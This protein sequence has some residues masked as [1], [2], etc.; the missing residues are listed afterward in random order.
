MIKFKITF[1]T[2]SNPADKQL[3]AWLTESINHNISIISMKYQQAR[4]G[5]HSICIMYEEKNQ[6]RKES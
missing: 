5:D 2:V 3:N 6:R 1:G 4:Y